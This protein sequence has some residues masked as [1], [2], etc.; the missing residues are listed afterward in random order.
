MAVSHSRQSESRTH[1]QSSLLEIFGYT[2]DVFP[3]TDFHSAT[4]LSNQI[5]IVGNLGYPKERRAGTTHS[6]E[7]RRPSRASTPPTTRTPSAFR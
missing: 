4:L 1:D 2:T 3:P 7:I 5:V 6:S